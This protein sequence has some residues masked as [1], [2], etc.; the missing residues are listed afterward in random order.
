MAKGKA[1]GGALVDYNTSKPSLV[2]SNADNSGLSEYEDDANVY[3]VVKDNVAGSLTDTETQKTVHFG[4]DDFDHGGAINNA[5]G[6]GLSD[7]DPV[8]HSAAEDKDNTNALASTET[9]KAVRVDGKGLHHGD[10]ANDADDSG[11]SDDDPVDIVHNGPLKDADHSS[12]LADAET[13]KRIYFD[14]DG[15]D[16]GGAINNA[17]DSGLSDDDPAGVY[18]VEGRDDSSAL[19]STETQGPGNV[20]S[21][22][23][24]RGDVMNNAD[25]SGLSDDDPVDNDA[26]KTNAYSSAGIDTETHESGP[27][28]GVVYDN[29][30][31]SGLSDDEAVDNGVV[32]DGAYGSAS[33]YTED[34]K[35]AH[36]DSRR[37]GRRFDYGIIFSN[38]D[39]D[40]SGLS[41]D[42]SV[43]NR[44]VGRKDGSSA[45]IGADTQ[46]TVRAF[47][48]VLA[49]ADDS[50]LSDDDPVDNDAAKTNADSSAGIDTETHESGPGHGVVCDNA[51][52]SALSDDEPVDKG[53]VKDGTYGSASKFTEIKSTV[54]IDDEGLGH[55]NFAKELLR[56][57]A[58]RIWL[59]STIC[60][61]HPRVSKY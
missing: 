43:G 49:D 29:A 60:F 16:H 20:D 23:L 40:D 17:D 31:D 13:Q 35:T 18:T 2:V 4:G 47:G 3:G 7:D 51:D 11:L 57:L 52:D 24:R 27:G 34:Q 50:G 15:F 32:R 28:Y 14:G 42:V 39:G 46:K 25:D 22:G 30:D 1:Y 54:H 26:A 12:A 6:S 21:E 5:D 41:N 56:Q 36:I 45:L 48:G 38:R 8:D 61:P 58:V 19:V 9:Q 59:H 53:V 44:E 55:G 33:K 10:V 37:F